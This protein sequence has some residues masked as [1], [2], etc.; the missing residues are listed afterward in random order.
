MSA[1]LLRQEEH[2]RDGA[3][4]WEVKADVWV[5]SQA[6]DSLQLLTQP[7]SNHTITPLT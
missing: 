2:S 1:S 3:A 6:L 5:G 7:A 4:S